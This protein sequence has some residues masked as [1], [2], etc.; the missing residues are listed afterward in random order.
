M[1]KQILY[2]MCSYSA[3]KMY[4][5]EQFRILGFNRH[6]NHVHQSSI[7]SLFLFDLHQ[8]PFSALESHGIVFIDQTLSF[9]GCRTVSSPVG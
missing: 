1:D 4:H 7:L 9:Y 3:E 6:R 5:G 2:N 8:S